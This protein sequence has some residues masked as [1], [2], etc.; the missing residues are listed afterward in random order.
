MSPDEE[1]AVLLAR[2][3]SERYP[4]VEQLEVEQLRRVRPP[5][6]TIDE[7]LLLPGRELTRLIIRE[8]KP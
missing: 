6:F 5:P 2:L 7:S 4:L 3:E 8:E 1:R